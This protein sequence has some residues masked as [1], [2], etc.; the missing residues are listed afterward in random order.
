[1]S[2]HGYVAVCVLC[3]HASW[4]YLN[5]GLSAVC[6]LLMMAQIQGSI[7]LIRAFF[8]TTLFHV[9]ATMLYALLF[10]AVQRHQTAESCSRSDVPCLCVCG[11]CITVSWHSCVVQS[12]LGPVVRDAGA[13][14]REGPLA[15]TK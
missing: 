12:V 4:Q 8:I 15:L 10:C 9:L 5:M 14:L 3:A 7:V 11:P 1:M 13:G 2:S 6:W